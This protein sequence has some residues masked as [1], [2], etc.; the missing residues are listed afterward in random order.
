MTGRTLML[1]VA[2]MS[3]AGQARAE[4][5]A[6]AK[7]LLNAHDGASAE[8]AARLCLDAQPGDVATWS[9]LGQAIGIQGRYGEAIG[10]LDRALARFPQDEELKVIRTRLLAWS[11]RL[12]EAWAAGTRLDPETL[13]DP[14][15]ATVV[16]NVAL[17]RKDHAEA[18]RRYDAIL[19]RY[20]DYADARRGRGIARQELGDLAGA[21][22]DFAAHCQ[23]EPGGDGCRFA[24]AVAAR[25]SRLR[26][27]VAPGLAL[28]QERGD[29][30]T[31]GGEAELKLAEPLSLVAGIER[32]T[33]DFGAGLRSDAFAQGL[34]IVRLHQRLTISAGGGLGIARQFS[35]AWTAEIEPATRLCWRRVRAAAVSERK[36]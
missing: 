10:W 14:D 3:A 18:A 13:L 8:R 32:R 15:A 24:Q 25:R 6:E 19:T 36:T 27:R 26:L 22:E 31:L 30:Y 28:V 34:V 23:V 4:G 29:G 1:V 5:C 21:E 11:G 9:L 16:A 33:R 12:D 17:W 2:L 7:R 20:P 35:P